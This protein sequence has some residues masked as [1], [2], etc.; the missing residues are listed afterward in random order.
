VITLTVTDRYRLRELNPQSS[1]IVPAGRVMCCRGRKILGYRDLAQVATLPR[2]T[3]TVCLSPADY[4][5]VMEQ[6]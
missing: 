6:P 2:D 3:D 5:A 1:A 4:R